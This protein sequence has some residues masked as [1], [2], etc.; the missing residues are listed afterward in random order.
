V[1]RLL[2]IGTYS[3][4]DSR[5]LYACEADSETGALTPLDE[6]LLLSPVINPTY[7]ACQGDWVYTVCEM[8]EDTPPRRGGIAAFRMKGRGGALEHRCSL[9]CG[10]GSPC[11]VSV[12][13]G[14]RRLAV[15]QYKTGELY[16]IALA[17]DGLPTTVENVFRIEGHGPMASRQE[18][19]HVH[20]AL[21]SPDGKTLFSADLGVDLIYRYRIER[22]SVKPIE[23]LS[24]PSGSGP[25]HMVFSADGAL[26][27]VIG[28][29]D[30][31]VIGFRKEGADYRLLGH[32]P[33]LP[34]DFKGESWAA[35]IRLH[36]NGRWLYATNRGLDDV[37]AL[38][39][40]PDGSPAI[41][42]RSPTAN[43]PRGMIISPDGRFLYAAGQH[44]DRI[45]CF[46]IN[47]QTGGLEKRSGLTGIPSSVGF[48]FAD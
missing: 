8:S 36:P 40:Q 18:G 48:A 34:P 45:D 2:F 43:W 3:D 32:W 12:F 31:T 17:P 21:A 15:S 41:I 10:M 5:G 16:I 25:R 35:E 20:S 37:V 30:S 28:E 11:H 4:R 22:E 7:I 6:P 24:C 23:P 26:L 1:K 47:P 27:W 39:L 29:L 33:L 19:P 46:A 9:P 42:G 14:G 44:A 38:A 13:D